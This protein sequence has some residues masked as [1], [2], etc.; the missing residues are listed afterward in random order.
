MTKYLSDRWRDV[1][2]SKNSRRRLVHQRLKQEMIGAVDDRHID[3]YV[4]QRLGSK[5]TAEATTDD[6]DAMPNHCSSHAGSKTNLACDEQWPYWTKVSVAVVR[7]PLPNA[8][9]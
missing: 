3:V 5:E 7:N 6:H 9:R 2:F 1:A 4:S 8:S